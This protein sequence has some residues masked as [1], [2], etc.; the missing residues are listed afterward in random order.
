[1]TSSIEFDNDSQPC[2]AEI[3]QLAK[4]VI[5]EASMDLLETRSQMSL[6]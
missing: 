2:R 5:K 1:M 4:M 6:K 3:I